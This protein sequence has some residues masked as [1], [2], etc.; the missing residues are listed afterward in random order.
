MDS[1]KRPIKAG[2]ENT[3]M[4]VFP[5]EAIED[6]VRRR[7]ERRQQIVAD[8]AAGINQVAP[9]QHEPFHPRSDLSMS[10]T[11]DSRGRHEE[12][13]GIPEGYRVVC[14]VAGKLPSEPAEPSGQ[15]T[16]PASLSGGHSL[17]IR[18]LCLPEL[19][20]E[21]EL[22]LKPQ[23]VALIHQARSQGLTNP[24]EVLRQRYP[25]WR[26]FRAETETSCCPKTGVFVPFCG[27]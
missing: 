22:P 13:L 25:A 14:L 6:A 8:R 1:K 10:Q 15:D 9:I 4:Q 5:V 3:K 17:W 2:G 24:R 16:S 21:E 20:Y 18:A 27:A 23:V 19:Q 12:S 11:T 7:Q 26:L